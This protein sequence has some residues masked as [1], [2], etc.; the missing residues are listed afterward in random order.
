MDERRGEV[1]K[2]R[3]PLLA[4]LRRGEEREEWM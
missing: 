1:C 3:E 4:C 2:R